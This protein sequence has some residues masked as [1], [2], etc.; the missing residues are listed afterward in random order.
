MKHWREIV[1][2]ICVFAFIILIGFVGFDMG[3]RHK[4]NEI[5]SRAIM[6]PDSDCFSELQLEYVIFGSSQE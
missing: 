5:V 2:L 3:Q 6:L 4:R 1:G